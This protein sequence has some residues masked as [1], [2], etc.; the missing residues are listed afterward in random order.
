M[1]YGHTAIVNN[2]NFMLMWQRYINNELM[3]SLFTSSMDYHYEK[4]C[5]PQAHCFAIRTPKQLIYNNITTILW[6]YE[7][8]LL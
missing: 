2:C 3:T 4:L 8:L 7:K 5:S 6:K 1:A